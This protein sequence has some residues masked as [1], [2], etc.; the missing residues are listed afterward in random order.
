MEPF[1]V[2]RQHRK[3]SA[4]E[5]LPRQRATQLAQQQGVRLDLYV[6]GDEP[7]DLTLERAPD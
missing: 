7:G 3:A 2:P 1:H 6:V 5:P 4:Q